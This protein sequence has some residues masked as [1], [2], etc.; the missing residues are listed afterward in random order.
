MKKNYILDACAVI[1][2]IK[3]EE[4]ALVIAEL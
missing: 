2:A 1:A 4:G 3:Q